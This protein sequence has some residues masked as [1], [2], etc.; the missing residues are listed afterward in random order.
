MR[1]LYPNLNIGIDGGIDCD[2]I[3]IV[4]LAGANNIVSGTGIYKHPNPKEGMLFMKEFVEKNVIQ[5]KKW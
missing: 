4:S 2:N 1:K 5:I 3:E